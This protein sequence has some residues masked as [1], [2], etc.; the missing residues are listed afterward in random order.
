MMINFINTF[1][2]YIVL[3]LAIVVIAGIAV[4]IGTNMR[5]KKNVEAEQLAKS[6][7]SV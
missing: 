6:S 2:S 5:K 7:D 1:L 3:M 4:V